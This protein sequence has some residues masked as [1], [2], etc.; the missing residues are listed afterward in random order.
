M[1]PE[2]ASGRSACSDVLLQTFRTFQQRGHCCCCYCW[3]CSLS[4]RVRFA[5][6]QRHHATPR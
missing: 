6:T 2:A 4:L 1:K 5:S 3:S